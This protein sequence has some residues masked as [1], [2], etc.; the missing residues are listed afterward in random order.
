[1]CRSLAGW[2]PLEEDLHIT[3]GKLVDCHRLAAT[4]GALPVDCFAIAHNGELQ[5][6]AGYVAHDASEEKK[7]VVYHL[8]RVVFAYH[9]GCHRVGC[10]VSA[11]RIAAVLQ[12]HLEILTHSPGVGRRENQRIGRIAQL[13]RMHGRKGGA[14]VDLG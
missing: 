3:R 10:A 4:I 5:A 14:R 7:A 6:D 2:D 12:S 8:L 11:D 1:S 9:Y 13:D